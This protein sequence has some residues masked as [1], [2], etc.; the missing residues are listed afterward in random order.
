MFL[1]QW[2]ELVSSPDYKDRLAQLGCVLDTLAMQCLDCS[3]VCTLVGD[4]PVQVLVAD[5]GGAQF[6]MP[7]EP[8][9]VSHSVINE[10]KWPQDR[11]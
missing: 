6:T 1:P 8:V 4:V 9:D 11:W 10:G 5:M 3:R 2:R 7:H